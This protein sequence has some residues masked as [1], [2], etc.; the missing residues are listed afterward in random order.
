M[1]QDR[2]ESS[3][4]TTQPNA[5]YGH[6]S[7]I[8]NSRSAPKANAASASPNAPNQ[9][10]PPAACKTAHCSPIPICRYF[11]GHGWTRTGD[12]SRVNRPDGLDPAAAPEH[13]RWNA[14]ERLSYLRVEKQATE[15]P[16]PLSV[17]LQE[18]LARSPSG[19]PPR[20]TRSRSTPASG[21]AKRERRGGQDH[22][23]AIGTTCPAIVTPPLPLR[24][25]PYPQ[26]VHVPAQARQ[27]V[28]LA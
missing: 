21:T 23:P 7:S 18:R 13:L 17:R 9:P 22:M 27:D 11:D 5:H 19:T 1:N 6:R 10:P 26:M 3:R 15:E 20:S 4:P 8:E 25:G 24:P 14:L 28:R 2:R 16:E 12:L